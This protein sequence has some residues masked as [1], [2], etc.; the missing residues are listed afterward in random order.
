M[1]ATSVGRFVNRAQLSVELRFP[2]V[3]T[4]TIPKSAPPDEAVGRTANSAVSC[5]RFV[6]VTRF[7]A[8]F[9]FRN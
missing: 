2:F 8:L 6:H 3:G 5:K 1:V 4:R 7:F 9:F